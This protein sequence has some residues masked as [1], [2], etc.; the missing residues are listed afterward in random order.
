[1]PSAVAVDG[2]DIG[3]E[4]ERAQ[5][6]LYPSL[7]LPLGFSPNTDGGSLESGKVNDGAS[8]C[9]RARNPGGRA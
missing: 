6:A 5:V 2:T 1:M 4:L 7:R 3:T 9:L 8:F